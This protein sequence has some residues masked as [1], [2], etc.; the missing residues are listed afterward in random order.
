MFGGFKS[1]RFGDNFVSLGDFGDAGLKA[2]TTDPEKRAILSWIGGAIAAVAGGTFALVNFVAEHK[3][4]HD[5][6]PT[7]EQIEQIQ[8][9]LAE[10]LAAERTRN[11]NLIKLLLEKNPAAAPGAP[12][13]VGAAVASIAQG[14]EEGDSRLEKALGL[15]KE[16]KIAEASK[17]SKE[18]A[19]VKTAHAEQATQQAEKATAQAEK[20]RKEAAAAYATSARLRALPIPS[21]RLRLT[22]RRSRSIRTIS[23]ACIGQATFWSIMVTSKKRKRGS[24]KFSS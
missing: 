6:G 12:Q 9:P 21:A 22:K 23:R 8:K 11:D 14:A 15:L 16:N 18:V 3:G 2:I 5:Q 13:A 10:E 19:E 24:S 1:V 4:A 20:D 7:K 17:L